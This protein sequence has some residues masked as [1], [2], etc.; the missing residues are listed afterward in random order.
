V[1]TFEDGDNRAMTTDRTDVMLRVF[2]AIN[3]RDFDGIGGDRSEER[4][5]REAIAS[6]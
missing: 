4:A 2:A 5:A 3:R 6:R 1:V